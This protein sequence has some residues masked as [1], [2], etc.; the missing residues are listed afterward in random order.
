MRSIQI[1]PSGDAVR[2]YVHEWIVGIEDVTAD[3]Q[4]VRDLAR[5]STEAAEG[6]RA[7]DCRARGRRRAS[8]G[9]EDAGSGRSGVPGAE[10]RARGCRS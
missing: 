10:S 4:H 8:L 2:R 9:A 5:T 6:R 7:A 3:M 1:G